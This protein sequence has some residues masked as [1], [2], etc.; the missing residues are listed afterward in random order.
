M[1]KVL[2]YGGTG[3]QGCAVVS[4]LLENGHTPYVLTR[5]P[6]AHPDL[7]ERG[8]QLV[9]GDMSD[10]ASLQAASAG[11][12]AVALTVPFFVP[13]AA[14]G[15][16]RNAIDAAKA[17]GVPHLVY[18]TSGPVMPHRLGN[19]SLDLRQDIIDHLKASGLSHVILKPTVYMENLLGPWTRLGIVENDTLAYPVPADV[20]LGWLA[21]ADFG[22]LMVAA[23][24][25][26]ELNGQAFVIS[27]VENLTGPELAAH[28]TRA[29]G[30]T[31]TYQAITPAE[32]GALLDRFIAPGAGAAAET[33]YTFQQ[34]NP[35]LFTMWT[36]MQP[37][38][39]K[40]PVRLTPVVEWVSQMSSLFTPQPENQ[41][42]SI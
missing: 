28:F 3:A 22:A 27:G 41:S 39:E 17:A 8:V 2:V 33:S 23:L 19:P 20:P 24:E 35:H 42:A 4:K 30:R 37:V 11:M 13:E 10:T 25:R 15:Y 34:E 7:H 36:D 16:A 32:F 1:M 26:P 5:H 14:L 6:D 40:L 12:D 21:H 38:L 18:N 31:I 9:T 29:L